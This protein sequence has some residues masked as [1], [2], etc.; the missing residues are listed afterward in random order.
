VEDP[1]RVRV[2][3]PL[4]SYAA[5]FTAE[6]ARLGYTRGS[7][8]GQMLLMAHVSRWL[9]GEGLD[10]GGLTAEAAE[11]FLG[12]R[13]AAGYVQL[14]SPKALG[15]LLGFLR[16]IGAVPEAPLPVPAGPAEEL[17]DRFRRYLMTERGLRTETA[18]DYA[19]KVRPFLAAC[20][21][22]GLA[23]LT[24]AEVTAF[25]VATCRRCGRGQRS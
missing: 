25:I 14:L 16:R 23:G 19:A 3:G 13:R 4:E 21:E 17:L 5:G 9:A 18:A 15:P 8:C 1:S 6:L 12:A 10:A 11:R 24:A 20:M 7:A 2:R 22:R